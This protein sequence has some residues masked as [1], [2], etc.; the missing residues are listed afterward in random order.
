MLKVMPLVDPADPHCPSLWQ[1]FLRL[2]AKHGAAPDEDRLRALQLLIGH[3]EAVVTRTGSLDLAKWA[4][5]LR[6]GIRL[7]GMA[8]RKHRLDPRHSGGILRIV[9]AL[10]VEQGELASLLLSVPV[11]SLDRS[12]HGDAD[13]DQLVQ[14]LGTCTFAA[15]SLGRLLCQSRRRRHR[16]ADFVTS[17]ALIGSAGVDLAAAAQGLVAPGRVQTVEDLLALALSS[18]WAKPQGCPS[19]DRSLLS[20]FAALLMGWASDSPAQPSREL[21]LTS[22]IFQ[23]L[24]AF[25]GLTS[26]DLARLPVLDRAIVVAHAPPSLLKSPLGKSLF[27]EFIQ[28]VE[29]LLDASADLILCFW[30]LSA[31]VKIAAEAAQPGHCSR[32]RQIC[33]RVLHSAVPAG[34][35]GRLLNLLGR[36]LLVSIRFLEAAELNMFIDLCQRLPAH[37]G[38]AVLTACLLSPTVPS[39]HKRQ[40]DP[41]LKALL[42]RALPAS[43][44]PRY[45]P[46]LLRCCEI[47]L[48]VASDVS[49]FEDAELSYLHRAIVAFLRREDPLGGGENCPP[50]LARVAAVLG[51]DGAVPLMQPLHPPELHLTIPSTMER[52]LGSLLAQLEGQL[53]TLQ[54]GDP[55]ALQRVLSVMDRLVSKYK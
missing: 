32:L 36:G 31:A 9:Q 16:W 49:V 29:Q 3:A 27:L 47:F 7:N 25:K 18:S 52:G 34:L 21:C 54:A 4:N 40:L 43:G 41:H 19:L 45:D 13:L 14:R 28:L 5:I 8:L 15:G 1:C 42:V 48:R 44:C 11:H 22:H 6:A 30:P 55:P 17:P 24:L 2:L 10:P 20:T 53:S 23:R 51:G 50:D 35:G 26:D 33:Q 46:N 12:S 37:L 39:D 38:L